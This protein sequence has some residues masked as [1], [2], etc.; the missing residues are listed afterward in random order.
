MLSRQHARVVTMGAGEYLVEDLG[1]R[2]GTWVNGRAVR[3]ERLVD[4]SIFETGRTA[5]LF[6]RA[7]RGVSRTRLD[8]TPRTFSPRMHTLF[9][10]GEPGS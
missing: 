3:H 1:S 4:G 2:N 10:A 5:W 8:R 7:P 9:A 6:R